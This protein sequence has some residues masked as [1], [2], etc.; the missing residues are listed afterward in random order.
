ME[1]HS[2][3]SIFDPLLRKIHQNLKTNIYD[4]KDRVKLLMKKLCS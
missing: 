3:R 4:W 1:L 2:W